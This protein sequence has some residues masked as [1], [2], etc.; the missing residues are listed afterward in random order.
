MVVARMWSRG[1][2]IVSDLTNGD[3]EDNGSGLVLVKG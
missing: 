1:C 3:G 2:L